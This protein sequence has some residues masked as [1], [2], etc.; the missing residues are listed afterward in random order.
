MNVCLYFYN[1]LEEMPEILSSEESIYGKILYLC[2]LEV[3][4]KINRESEKSK[5]IFKAINKS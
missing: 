5:T 2:R 3:K 4:K 1:N